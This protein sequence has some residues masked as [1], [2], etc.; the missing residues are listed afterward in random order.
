MREGAGGHPTKRTNIRYVLGL[1]L[2][3][4]FLSYFHR[5]ASGVLKPEIEQIALSN[6]LRPER[7]LGLFAS[8]YFYAY[9]FAQLL[10][11]PL[12]DSLGVRRA[13]SLFLALMS[14]GTL[15]VSSGDPLMLVVGR[16]LVGFSASVAYLAYHKATFLYFSKERQGVLAAIAIVVG[17]AGSLASA[18]PLRA[19]MSSLGLSATMSALGAATAA[20]AA[21]VALSGAPDARGKF[22]E[23]A[24]NTLRGIARM[25]RDPHIYGIGVCGVA[26]Y[27]VIVSFQSSWGQYYFEALGKDI[28]E[29][30]E[31]LSLIPLVLIPMSLV[32]G[33]MSDRV[34][35]RRKPFLLVASALSLSSW[36]LLRQALSSGIGGYSLVGVIALGLAVAFHIVQVAAAKEK[37]TPEISASTV[38]MMN[39]FTFTGIA[40]FNTLFPLIGVERMLVL[41]GLAAAAGL[42]AVALLVKETLKDS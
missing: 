35:K 27:G 8:A 22:A 6:G 19:L 42:P 7:L 9:A 29:A 13:T 11:G 28:R 17:N 41:S 34:V 12:I 3:A 14:A 32:V 4:Y 1:I 33:H 39:V 20:V 10:V 40:A 21:A 16:F 26:T 36:I 23:N 31:Y 38:A 18:Y 5:T 15:L 24:R 2:S 30:S 25:L 37:Y